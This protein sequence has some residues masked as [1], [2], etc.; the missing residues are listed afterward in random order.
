MHGICDI[1]VL[2]VYGVHDYKNTVLLAIVYIKLFSDVY[3]PMCLNSSKPIVFQF[4]C[5][6][7]KRHLR[8]R[9]SALSRW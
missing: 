8:K 5:A 7:R 4:G 9:Y 1:V 2:L 6:I 3:V